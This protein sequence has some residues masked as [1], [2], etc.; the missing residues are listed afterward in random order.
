M[1]VMRRLILMSGQ[2]SEPENCASFDR[3]VQAKAFI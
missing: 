1:H 2:A 3:P